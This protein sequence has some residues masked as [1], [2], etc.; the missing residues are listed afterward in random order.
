MT[1]Y[2]EPFPAARTK[3]ATASVTRASQ[4]GTLPRA[5]R[6]APPVG[7]NPDEAATG[8]RPTDELGLWLAHTRWWLDVGWSSTGE[9]GRARA[10][11]TD[12]SIQVGDL[13]NTS[14]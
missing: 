3:M 7:L 2:I 6:N 11:D 13:P 12:C 10:R 14:G 5:Q 4:K 8:L 9:H 1:R